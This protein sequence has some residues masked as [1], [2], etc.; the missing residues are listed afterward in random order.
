[1]AA[2]DDTAATS[3]VPRFAATALGAALLPS[4]AWGLGAA[5]G[6]SSA[7]QPVLSLL[8]VL[9]LPGALIVGGI[10]ALVAAQR[11]QRGATWIALLAVVLALVQIGIVLW[12]LANL[13]C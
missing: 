1:M 6:P 3:S 2:A 8:A 5:V 11:Q 13:A 4:I 7:W 10:T 12:I 9:G